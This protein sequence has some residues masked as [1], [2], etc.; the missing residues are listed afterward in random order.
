MASAFRDDITI[1]D[2]RRLFVRFVPDDRPGPRLTLEGY[3]SD[4]TCRHP[5]H[6]LKGGP[7]N[8]LTVKVTRQEWDSLGSLRERSAP[9]GRLGSRRRFLEDVA[10]IRA[11]IAA[12]AWDLTADEARL[13]RAFDDFAAPTCNSVGPVTRGSQDARRR[14][15]L[16]ASP[17]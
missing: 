14:P 2:T 16:A 10:R 11:A 13:L 5:F 1:P 9:L 3:Y 4:P 12:L 17:A 8:V 15:A 7:I 6:I